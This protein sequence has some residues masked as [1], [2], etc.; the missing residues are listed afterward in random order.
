MLA[1]LLIGGIDACLNNRFGLGDSFKEGFMA[2]GSLVI[3][4]VGMNTVAPLL[5]DV[6]SGVLV[7]VFSLIGA[8]P[9][10][11]AGTILPNDSGGYALAMKLAADETLGGFAG[12]VVG[13]MMGV[14][15]SFTIP[16]GFSTAKTQEDR[17]CLARG[18]LIGI[19][20]LPFGCFVGGLIGG[21]SLLPLFLNLIPML[22][23]TLVLI[24]GL[25]FFP[26]ACVKAMNILGRIM[27]IFLIVTLLLAVFEHQTGIALFGGR[28][29]PFRESF[30][31]TGDIAIVLAGA[32]PLLRCVQKLL[33]K[34]LERL[35]SRFSINA[36]SVTGLMTTLINSIPT[37]G[38][39]HTM[40]PRGKI[41]NAAFA[42]SASFALGDH[43]GFTAGACPDQLLPMITGKLAGAVLALVV[44]VFMTRG[45][46]NE[47]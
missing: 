11:F 33:K 43:L 5:A 19:C 30:A 38:T 9:S 47:A 24:L 10:M 13:S 22:I 3:A 31:I 23:V 17:N 41:L 37:F 26:D 15:I 14:T 6:L 27:S 32:F 36:D 46:K 8:D 42:V 7:P 2:I 44:A 39:M 25:I 34:P 45:M 12:A 4:M 28:L 29:V 35:G 40:D 16:F 21:I 18:L 1:F 20:T